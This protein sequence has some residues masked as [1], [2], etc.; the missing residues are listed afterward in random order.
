MTA[1]ADEEMYNDEITIDF[2]ENA[3]G[4]DNPKIIKKSRNG[5]LVLG[6]GTEN[7]PLHVRIAY[8]NKGSLHTRYRIVTMYRPD[9]NSE[10]WRKG[11]EK[12]KKKFRLR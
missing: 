10:L 8:N 11:Y 2:F 12:K 4:Y 5:Y 9:R 3:I 7:E 1:H 6:W